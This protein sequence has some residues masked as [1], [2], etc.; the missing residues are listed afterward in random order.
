MIKQSCSCLSGSDAC[1]SVTIHYFCAISYGPG[2][3]WNCM[4]CSNQ[5]MEPWYTSIQPLVHHCPTS[6][7]TAN[8]WTSDHWMDQQAYSAHEF[9]PETQNGTKKLIFLFCFF[10]LMLCKN[11]FLVGSLRFTNGW[12][13]YTKCETL[14]KDLFLGTFRRGSEEKCFS[15]KILFL[16]FFLPNSNFRTEKLIFPSIVTICNFAR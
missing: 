15:E 3:L 2:N 8:H 7:T 16:K 10:F 4:H 14:K 5:W 13:C 11:L 9:F 1:F 12:L 6:G